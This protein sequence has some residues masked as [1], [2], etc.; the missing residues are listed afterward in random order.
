MLLCGAPSL[1][2]VIAFPKTKEAACLMTGAPDVVD[3]EQ[4]E[5]L[6][7]SLG[8]QEAQQRAGDASEAEQTAHI[9]VQRVAQLSMLSLSGEEE[10]AMEKDMKDI[11]SFANS[12]AQ[13]DTEG[14]PMT[15]HVQPMKNVWREDCKENSFSRESLLANVPAQEDGY[16]F[17]PKVVE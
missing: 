10:A 16:I 7:L 6:S 3:R 4:L 2:D 9:D 17:V 5:T 11:V 14:I 8:L 12:L 15:A 13:Y 1:R